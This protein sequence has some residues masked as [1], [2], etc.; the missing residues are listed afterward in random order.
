M[1][2]ATPSAPRS[3]REKKGTC[4]RQL[5]A[6]A[7]MAAT[8]LSNAHAFAQ[9]SGS[10][11]GTTG[12]IQLTAA[13]A[14]PQTCKRLAGNPIVS[15]ASPSLPA[16]PKRIVVLE[17]MFAE[18]LAAVGI[19]P[20]GMADPEYY[21]VWIGYDNAR[22]ASVPDIGTR[23]EP[24]LEAIAAAKPDLILGVG[25]RHAP[26]FAALERIAPTVLFKYGP[27]FT[28]DGA[29]VTQLDWSR[30][31]LR[32]IGCL[33][34]REDAARAV[35]AKVDAGFARDAQRLAE[36]G[37]G[38]EQVAWLQELGLPDRYWAFTGN[39][40]AAGVAHALGLN[41]WPAEA[42]REGTA[43]VSSEDLLKKPKLT[44]L[45]VTATEKGVPLATKLDSPI[46][47][48]VPAR[49]AGRVGLVERNIWGFGGPM[50][51]L[52]LADTM[53]DTLLSLPAPGVNKQ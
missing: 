20:V 45:F 41:L 52:R 9:G 43:Y 6:N 11:A 30:K 18:D 10:A 42:T 8:L 5:C 28:E 29:H 38:G 53:T 32:T 13:Q 16:Q 33:T 4:F 2:S 1:T 36:A 21:P 39:S 50:S 26:I 12:P 46:W 24:S 3:R 25:L 23:Q 27:N 34:G 47:R 49:S 15:Q 14:Q 51:A 35:E 37:R 40:T 31:I 19:T 44:V 17:F 48:F 22:L 7:V